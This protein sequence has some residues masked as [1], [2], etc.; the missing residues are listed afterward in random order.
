MGKD[1]F[2]EL[3]KNKV[4]ADKESKQIN[5]KKDNVNGDVNDNANN[6][7]TL[8]SKEENKK[9]KRTY[10]IHPEQDKNI[11]WASRKTGRDKSEIVRRA[12]DYFFEKIEIE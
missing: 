8:T 5:K 2:K 9:V 10:Y 11:S 3:E 1:I 7:V 4:K 12:L 6:R